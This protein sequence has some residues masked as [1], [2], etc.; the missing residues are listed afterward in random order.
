MAAIDVAGFVTDLKDH[1]V[2]HGFHVHDERHF[3]ETYSLRQWWE[4]DLH[5]EAGCGQPIDLHLALDVDPRVLLAF[6]DAVAMLPPD[7]EPDD[8]Y[9]FPLTFTWTVPPLPHQPDLLRLAVDLAGVSG[10]ELPLEVAAIDSYAS[11]TDA[12]ERRLTLTARH[13]VSLAKITNGKETLCD[14]FDRCM[15]VSAFLLDSL[16]AWTD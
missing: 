2:D 6:D 14:L 13:A 3:F 5:P 16:P 10:V 4:V 9:H 1:A 7:D 8:E 12:P 15:T 11:A